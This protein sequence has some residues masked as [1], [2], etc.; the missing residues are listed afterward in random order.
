MGLIEGRKCAGLKSGAVDDAALPFVATSCVEDDA[1][2]DSDDDDDE[3]FAT[4][5]VVAVVVDAAVFVAGDEEPPLGMNLKL[6][7]ESTNLITD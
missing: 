4:V 5:F 7:V 6:D 1:D 2:D 3:D